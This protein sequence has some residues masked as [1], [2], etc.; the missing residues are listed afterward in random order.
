MEEGC[1]HLARWHTSMCVNLLKVFI[2]S[3][4]CNVDCGISEHEWVG[5]YNQ[6]KVFF[7]FIPSFTTGLKTLIHYLPVLQRQA[8][9]LFLTPL[10]GEEME[11]E[12]VR[13]I[14]KVVDK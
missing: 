14:S 7:F 6:R 9:K 3:L 11:V 1:H 8:A 13:V 5:V 2:L 12:R 4:L 10:A